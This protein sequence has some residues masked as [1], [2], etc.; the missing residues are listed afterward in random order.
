MP[1]ARLRFASSG[2]SPGQAKSLARRAYER[3]SA[4]GGP[5]LS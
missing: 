5:W 2:L 4:N 3:A 1:T